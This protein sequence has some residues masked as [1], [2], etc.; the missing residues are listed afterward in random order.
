MARTRAANQSDTIE[1]ERKAT[2]SY[3]DYSL[4]FILFFLICFGLIMLY[5][6]S[7]YTSAN[8]YGDSAYYLKLQV[9]NYLIGFV[10]MV[11]LIFLD[12][13]L[14]EKMAFFIYIVSLALCVAVYIPGL[15][16]SSHGSSRWLALGPISFQPSEVGKV[17]VII[18]MALLIEKVPKEM[19]HF[20]GIMKVMCF[21]LPMV[22]LVAYM[23]LSTAIIIVGI[24]CCMTFCASS[25]VKPFFGVAL[26]LIGLGIVAIF[27]KGYRAGRLSSFFHPEQASADDVYQTYQGLYAIGSG[28]L[29]GKGLGQSLQKL[30]NVPESQNDFI[31]TIICEELGLF[32]AICTILLFVLLLWRMVVIANNAPD[33]YGSMLVVG[34]MAQ[35]AIQVV[36]NIAVVTNTIPNTGI[37]LPFI[38]YGGTSICILMAEMG[39]VLGVSRRIKLAK[40]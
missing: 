24:A 12:Y 18:F 8:K 2:R 35:I 10:A 11:V 30:G 9:R 20:G 19:D 27:A 23:N 21:L 33:L 38:S 15:G 16:T 1:K 4:L 3:F 22:G 25:K 32:G 31:F 34:V 13:H 7:S 17:A 5:S 28:G 37:V 29:F 36:L 6:S 40:L 14:W 39:I 26:V